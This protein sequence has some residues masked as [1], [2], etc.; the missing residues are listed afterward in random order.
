MTMTL[1]FLLITRQFGQ[2]GLTEALTFMLLLLFQTSSRQT[3]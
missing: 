1:P 3:A 2:I